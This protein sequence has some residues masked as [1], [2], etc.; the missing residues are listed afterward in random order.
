MPTRMVSFPVSTSF[1][2][3]C[4][5]TVGDDNGTVLTHPRGRNRLVAVEQAPQHRDLVASGDEPKNAA[6]AVDH[7]IGQRHPTPSLIDL[8]QR[9]I[10]VSDVE[11]W[12]TGYQGGRMAVGPQ[13]EM[14]EVEYRRRA[15]DHAEGLGVLRGR[16]FQVEGFDRHRVNLLG[17]QRSV[18]EQTLAQM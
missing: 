5:R 7:R 1:D 3:S 6:R 8:G 10:G 9:N 11:Y 12:I 16:S 2:L 14:D 4:R 15:G 13:A 18:I 17:T